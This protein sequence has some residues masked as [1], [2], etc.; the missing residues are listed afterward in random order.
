MATG[1]ILAA[2]VNA[3][4][5][6]VELDIEGFKIGGNRTFGR[7]ASGNVGAYSGGA[8]DTVQYPLDAFGTPKLVMTT[9]NRVGHTNTGAA[10]STLSETFLGTVSRRNPYSAGGA[11]WL[12]DETD[13]TTYITIRLS[14]DKQVFAGETLTLTGLADIYLDNGTG[15]SGLSS[16]A[17]SG[18]AV[19]ND[20]TETA[21]LPQLDWLTVPKQFIGSGGITLELLAT[22]YAG[23]Q[24]RML[25][26]ALVTMTGATSLHA[27]TK[28]VTAMT[29]P[30]SMVRAGTPT[31]N[32]FA[33][34]FG[35]ADLT[36]FT[37]GET[38]NVTVEGRP[39]IGSA[40]VSTTH[41]A[42]Y[43]SVNMAQS[44]PF[45]M[46]KNDALRA[47]A[48][49]DPAGTLTGASTAGCNWTATENTTAGTC[50]SSVD[51]AMTALY[52][53]M[54]RSELAGGV[55]WLRTGTYASLG[56]VTSATGKAPGV[57]WIDVTRAPSTS[58]DADVVITTTLGQSVT[59]RKVGGNVR[60]SNM[61]LESVASA[62]AG[63][64]I[65]FYGSDTTATPAKYIWL[66]NNT[67]NG[68]VNTAGTP[69]AFI[70]QVG[71]A[72]WTN[73]N[74]SRLDGASA[75]VSLKSGTG[76]GYPLIAGC[77]LNG[78]G[79]MQP[80]VVACCKLTGG[81]YFQTPGTTA[82]VPQPAQMRVDFTIWV[83]SGN[84]TLH[85]YGAASAAMPGGSSFVSSLLESFSGGSNPALQV[86]ADRDKNPIDRHVSAFSLITGQR[87]NFL[88]NSEG[89]VAVKKRGVRRFCIYGGNQDAA[90]A[91]DT[92][93]NKSDTFA[94]TFTTPG[95]QA[96][97]T[98]NWGARNGVDSLNN[99]RLEKSFAQNH[100]SPI[101]EAGDFD[102]RTNS[103]NPAP[104]SRVGVFVNDQSGTTHP[105]GGD[106][107]LTGAANPLFNLVPAG[108]AMLAYDLDGVARLDDG[109]GAIGPYERTDAAF[110]IT[111]GVALPAFVP[112]LD[113]TVL[114]Q[115]DVAAAAVL[116]AFRAALTGTVVTVQSLSST[117]IA[118]TFQMKSP[119]SVIDWTV[120]YDLDTGETITASSWAATPAES[121]GLTVEPGDDIS[122]ASTACL[123]SGG[124]FRHVYELTNTVETSLG[125]TLTRTLGFR[126]GPVEG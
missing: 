106:Y 13:N 96:G 5:F 93:F 26:A 11:H 87:Q 116:P 69:S 76:R 56:G 33:A 121:G 126:I 8:L 43:P 112:A 97:R 75:K 59:N 89:T 120:A 64:N 125:R 94:D 18:L 44:I 104:V 71:M 60:F 100:C 42:V 65:F 15:G 17:V 83:G 22:H 107:H 38:V 12:N 37:Q 92:Y 20:S 119:A 62:T 6:T 68:G 77:I 32:V 67:I 98:G 24:R 81:T 91:D 66:D 29:I 113:V 84:N 47:W 48:T 10:S 53:F 61:T 95:Q 72:Y 102:P 101:G 74:V 30:A 3:D 78:C 9:S 80:Y 31:G 34:T 7:T 85:H 105:G 79:Q 36:G 49:V 52:T 117:R 4:G 55:V 99:V 21:P 88:Y 19:T 41:G 82:T 58:S 103:I 115:V 111:A 54:G 122:G 16:N 46:D 27:V 57:G 23:R 14:I 123:V 51:H 28:T 73:N 50:Y 70:H 2:R 86:S 1:D 124:V 110:D 45:V 63:D 40:Y 90:P 118:N 39:W 109:T 108:L 35:P 25:A 114:M